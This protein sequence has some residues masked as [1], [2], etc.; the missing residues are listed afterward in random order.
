VVNHYEEKRLAEV[1]REYGEDHFASR[2]ASFIADRRARKPIETT[3]EL[4]EIITAAIP[5]KYRRQGP[6]P[7][8][9]TFQ[10]VRIEVNG[11]LEGLAQAIEDITGML[12]ENGRLCVLD[13][14]SGEDRQVKQAMKRMENPC[15]CPKDAPMC[16]CGRKPMGRMLTR[17]PEEPDSEEIEQNPRARSAK[18]RVFER[19]TRSERRGD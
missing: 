19:S 14:H 1:I 15:I 3:G 10:A 9:R 17:K 18:L 12:K 16:V 13:F 5:A 6:H 8:K 2:I 4:A 7:A 11:E